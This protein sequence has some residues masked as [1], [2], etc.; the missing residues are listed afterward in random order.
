MLHR[1]RYL[2]CKNTF[3]DCFGYQ[4]KKGG[5]IKELVFNWAYGRKRYYMEQGY[6]HDEVMANHLCA[7]D[8][9][10]CCLT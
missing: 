5:W 2:N 4:V 3:S 10:P 8:P 9:L 1:E 7:A 6:R